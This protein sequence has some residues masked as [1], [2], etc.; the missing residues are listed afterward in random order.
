MRR[1]IVNTISVKIYKAL[2]SAGAPEENA[3]EVASELDAM[4]GKLLSLEKHG[5]ITHWLLGFN[6]FLELIMLVLLYLKVP[7]R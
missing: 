5:K 1:L 7:C 4:T 2:K 3:T 6:I